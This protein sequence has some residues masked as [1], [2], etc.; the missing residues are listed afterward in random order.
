MTTSFRGRSMRSVSA[1]SM[2]LTMSMPLVT[3]PNTTCLPART[4]FENLPHGLTQCSVSRRARAICQHGERGRSPHRPATA[5]TPCTGRTC[6]HA[7]A[8]QASR[9]A[10]LRSPADAASTKACCQRVTRAPHWEPLVLGPALAMDR[11]PA[12]DAL[13][14]ALHGS[15]PAMPGC[16]TGGTAT[17]CPGRLPGPVCRN[18]KFSSGNLVP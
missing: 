10:P 5:S 6:M 16:A 1:P 14:R 8:R 3:S 18:L 7:R 9:R 11:T 2:R 4:P 12:P 13:V 15:E 17:A